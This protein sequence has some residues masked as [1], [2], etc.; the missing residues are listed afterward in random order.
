MLQGVGTQGVAHAV[1]HI[2]HQ[3]AFV[4]V[5]NLVERARNMKAHCIHYLKTLT[6]SH[7]LACEPF[8]VGETKL[9]LVAVMRCLCAP[10]D[11]R[12]CGQLYLANTCEGIGDLLL[13]A[14]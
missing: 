1:V 9:Q 3:M 5:Q 8:L 2:V 13:L 4:N 14:A 7:L 12:D 10:Q 6:G 11:G